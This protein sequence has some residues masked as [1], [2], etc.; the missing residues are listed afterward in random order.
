MADRP[1]TRRN[2]LCPLFSFLGLTTPVVFRAN[3]G[4][5]LSLYDPDNTG[6]A[7]DHFVGL[8]RFGRTVDQFY[9][10]DGDLVHFRYGY[11]PDGNVLF[12]QDVLHASD[13]ELYTYDDLNRLITFQR[14]TLNSTH[15]AITGPPSVDKSWSLDALGNWISVTTN[16]ITQYRAHD[17]Q[18]E[19]TSVG[20]DS[21]SYDADGNLTNYQ[22]NDYI[23]DG[24]N[25]LVEV[26][27]A[28]TDDRVI[29]N[30]C[31]RLSAEHL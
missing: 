3:S 13:S 24:W 27:L 30:G 31:R 6:D 20:N 29:H 8:D 18:N 2:E 17:L 4:F 19:L 15:T 10:G 1:S 28:S 26:R 9:G 14:G 11:D 21:L 5:V 12:K 16:G 25:R 23:Y 7:G 22:D